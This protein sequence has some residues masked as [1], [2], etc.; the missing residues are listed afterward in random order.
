VSER[1]AVHGVGE[2]ANKVGDLG[3]GLMRESPLTLGASLSWKKK[4]EECPLIFVIALKIYVGWSFSYD[5]C[6][7]PKHVDLVHMYAWT[8]PNSMSYV[9]LANQKIICC[10]GSKV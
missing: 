8:H 3:V 7:S 10:L 1:L 6:R 9:G 5:G 2:G 4:K